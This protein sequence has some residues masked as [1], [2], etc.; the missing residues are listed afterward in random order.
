M[1][2]N[3]DKSKRNRSA[4][5]P[6][7][8]LAE[9]VDHLKLIHNDLGKGPYDRDS[10]AKSIG[11][12]GVSGAS[13]SKIAALVHYG[14]IQRVGSGYIETELGTSIALSIDQ[15]EESKAL[16]EAFKSPT[17]FSKL[18]SDFSGKALPAKLEIILVRQYRITEQASKDAAKA[19]R[20]S[21]EFVGVL[22]NGFLTSEAETEGT[23]DSTGSTPSSI[24]RATANTPAYDAFKPAQ[25]EVAIEVGPGVKVV[26]S[27]ELMLHMA[28][29]KFSKGIEQLS[30]DL[31]ALNPQ[32]PLV[33][34]V[35][36]HEE[37]QS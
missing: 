34:T 29:G 18:L 35:D 12:N 5:Y 14:L 24:E 30:K 32:Q 26:F 20:E 21:A 15:D 8:S 6:S 23:M 25:G 16:L 9:A 13:A 37:A 36:N 33:D 28:T 27:N 19:F 10:A 3:K 2:D 22:K 7:S 11:Y 17:L 31:V 1:D 4:A